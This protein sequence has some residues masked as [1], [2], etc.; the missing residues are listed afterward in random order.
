MAEGEID[1]DGDLRQLENPVKT[2]IRALIQVLV[3]DGANLEFDAHPGPAV[4]FASLSGRLYGQ[5]NL[6]DKGDG[7]RI[8]YRLHAADGTEVHAGVVAG[9]L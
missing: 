8:A 3:D 6:E 7:V 9:R 2:F 5:A 4:D 1:L